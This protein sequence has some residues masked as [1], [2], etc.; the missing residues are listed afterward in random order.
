LP[1]AIGLTGIILGVAGTTEISAPG[2]SVTTTVKVDKIRI[3]S[4]QD[5]SLFLVLQAEV[6]LTIGTTIET[7]L[8]KLTIVQPYV[9]GNRAEV[10][11]RV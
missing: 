1:F 2:T 5:A 8:T 7:K 9:T 6:T 3:E 10:L 11:D 4:K